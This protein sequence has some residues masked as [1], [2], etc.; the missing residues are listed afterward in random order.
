MWACAPIYGSLLSVRKLYTFGNI[1]S[2]LFLFYNFSPTWKYQISGAFWSLAPEWQLYLLFPF[3]LVPLW[4][5]FG[6]GALLGG[7]L[8]AT[9]G[10]MAGGLAVRLMHPW[11]LFLFACGIGGAVIATSTDERLT[12]IRNR[13]PW[14]VISCSLIGVILCEWIVT[15]V[16]DPGAYVPMPP[17]WSQYCVNEVLLGLSMLAAFL[18][19]TKVQR[20][21]A[22]PEWPLILRIFHSRPATWLGHMSYSLYLTHWPVV[23]VCVALVRSLKWSEGPTL[24]LAYLA[25]IPATI[26]T[27]YVF[28]L[29]VERRCLPNYN[30]PTVRPVLIPAPVEAPA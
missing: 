29:V 13:V 16:F 12:S 26:V 20:S 2:H 23:I 17:T 14:A 19:W 6:L 18:H 25:T 1:V 7:S 27:G 3:I 30:N 11:Y 28:F 9:C 21:R 4:R 15:A 5:K 10:L 8:L 24:I 22:F